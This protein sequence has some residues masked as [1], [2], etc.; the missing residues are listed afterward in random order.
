MVFSPYLL[1]L[2]SGGH[3]RL[4][5]GRLQECTPWF[6]ANQAGL[7]VEF[8]MNSGILRFGSV[9]TIQSNSTLTFC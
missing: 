9:V 8:L 2:Q 1:S 7:T 6:R 5:H 4:G 3:H